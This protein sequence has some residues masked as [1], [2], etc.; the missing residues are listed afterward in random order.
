[1]TRTLLGVGLTALLGFALAPPVEALETDQYYSWGRPLAD[2]T[3]VLNAKFNLELQRAIDNFDKPPEQCMDIPIRFR[4]NMRSL[5]FHSIQMWAM[6]SA[7]LERIPVDGGEDLDFRKVNLY[8]VHGFFDPGMWMTFTP[9]IEVN[10]VRIGTDKVSHFVSSGWTYYTS[11]NKALKNGKT[12]D[13][14]AQA[15]VRRGILEESLILGRAAAGI[16]SLADLEANLQGMYFYLNMC[17]GDNPTLIRREDDWH[18]ARP[19][20]LRDYVHPRWDE[21]YWPCLY[22]K[23]RWRKVREGLVQYCDR[24]DHPQVLEMH[25]R[26]RGLERSSVAFEVVTEM[27]AGGK[28]DDPADYS[29]EANCPPVD[30]VDT[31]TEKAPST[32][33]QTGAEAPPSVSQEQWTERIIAEEEDFERRSIRIAAARISYPQVVSGS[34]GWIFARQPTTYDCR[35][36]C[37][38]VGPFAQLEPGLGGGKASFGF[39][40][41]IGEHRR[42]PFAL[43]SVYL[44]MGIKGSVLY[45]WGERSQVPPNQTYVGPEFEFSVAR[46]NMGVGVLGR[47]G[48]DEGHDWIVTGWLGWGF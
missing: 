26:Y 39:G 33:A 6:N 37:N 47:V 30:A 36:P 4:K 23:G 11:Y 25:D 12:P 44:A 7:L 46:V 38:L 15:A 24:L 16:F 3:D 8:H 32:T 21:S 27:I 9:T 43:S 48:G 19:I 28:L 29:L 1:M 45:S 2:S 10:G 14:A 35:T 20:D 31:S 13:E 40:R 42:G 34:F 41:V 18:I 5:L 17:G 22:T